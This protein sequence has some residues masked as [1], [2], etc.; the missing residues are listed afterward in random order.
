MP[1]AG[2]RGRKPWS[3]G[4]GQDHG[5]QRRQNGQ[6]GARPVRAQRLGH[7]PDRL[8]HDGHGDDL[9]PVHPAGLGQPLVLGDAKG[10]QDQR[11][12]RWQGESG[13]GRQQPQ[14]A[15][16]AQPQRHTD[17]AAGRPRQELAQGDQIGVAAVIQPAATLDE[18]RAEIAQMRDRP[19]EGGQPQ[20]EEG[21]EDFDG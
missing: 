9:E 3:R 16:A 11:N 2:C 19:A 20:L 18:L 8:R 21:A 1:R 14:P 5:Q 13:P 15:R 10:E 12:R 7:P 17:L 4:R 6:R